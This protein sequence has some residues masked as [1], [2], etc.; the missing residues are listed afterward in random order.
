MTFSRKTATRKKNLDLLG[1]GHPLIDALINYMRGEGLSGEVLIAKCNGL[2]RCASTR[3]VFTVEFED[4]TKRDLYRN[5]VVDGME[6]CDDLAYLQNNALEPGGVPA[7]LDLEIQLEALIRNEEA[8]IRSTCNG[9][10]NIRNKCVGIE[11][12]Y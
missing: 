2:T 10:M 4:G 3:Y 11:F 12:L 9:V 1:L 8:K 7:K 5:F 6:T